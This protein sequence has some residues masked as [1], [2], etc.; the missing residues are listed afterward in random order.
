M[1][2]ISVFP[3][4]YPERERSGDAAA[5][6]LI[7]PHGGELIDLLADAD[8]AAELKAASRDWP[9]WDLTPRQFCDLELLLNG[10]FSPLTGFMEKADYDSVCERM[11]LA[12]GTLW[13]IPVTARRHPAG[14]REAA[15]GRDAGAAR[16]RGGDARRPPRR[17]D[18]GAR[19]RGRGRGGLR[20]HRHRSTP[21]VA[22]LLNQ[23]NR[24]R[25]RRPPRGAPA[26]RRTTTSARLRQTPAELRAE[27]AR[28]GWRRVVAFQ[29]RNPMHRAH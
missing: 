10:G 14:G 15:R 2:N 1:S 25:R 16:P 18:V 8:R 6:H 29:T 23:T 26:P 13:P 11:R 28:E 19:P 21:A 5:S 4:P 27:F 22:H 20:H 24:R 3:S 7:A 9:S 17:G 12:D